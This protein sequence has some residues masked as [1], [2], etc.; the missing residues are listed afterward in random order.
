MQYCFVRAGGVGAGSVAGWL[1]GKVG[2]GVG[3][4]R[5]LPGV[6]SE[7]EA[8]VGLKVPV[9]SPP[10]KVETAGLDVGLIVGEYDSHVGCVVSERI[11]VGEAVGYGPCGFDFFPVGAAVGDCVRSV[12]TSS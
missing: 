9:N 4:P 1:L 3:G 8:L 7:S 5:V 10:N 2:L 12:L 6:G 11:N